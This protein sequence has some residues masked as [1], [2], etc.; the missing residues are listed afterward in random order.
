MATEIGKIASLWRYP[1]KSMTG[2]EL[3]EAEFTEFGV[4]GDRAY[5]LIDRTDGK[6]ATAKNPGKWPAM[7]ACR[8]AFA[9]APKSGAGIPPVRI[10][11]PDGSTVMS[12]APECDRILSEALKRTVTLA[13]AERGTIM[14]VQSALPASW[15]GK[16]EEYRLDMDG[17]EQ[18]NSV[19]EFTLPA[20][21][22][23]DG[24]IVHL[25]TT[26][27]LNRLHEAYPQGRFDACRFRPNM[28]LATPE[29]TEGFIEQTWIGRTLRIG[30]VQL[31]LTKPTGR[32]VMTTLAQG[33][34]PRD[35]GILRTAVQQNHG[36]VGVYAAVLTGGTLSRGDRVSLS[37]ET[38][39]S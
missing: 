22:F 9:G 25:V 35:T 38:D 15:S 26:A 8:A 17:I 12:T 11:L 28:L 36:K 10:T 23:F 24:A 1:V 29:G 31:K 27:T 6:T 4:T 2:E 18:R 21:T 19:L 39:P 3:Q 37:D 34:L 13:S 5:A 33:D 7:F 30:A 20:G 14:G 16:S 32:C